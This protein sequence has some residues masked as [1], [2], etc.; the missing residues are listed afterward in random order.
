MRPIFILSKPHRF[1]VA[2]SCSI[3]LMPF[4][5][6]IFHFFVSVFYSY[7]FFFISILHIFLSFWFFPCSI[8]FVVF[9]SYLLFLL[10]YF[11][12]LTIFWSSYLLY[13]LFYAFFHIYVFCFVS[14]YILTLF[15]SIWAFIKQPR[16]S[17]PSLQ[18]SIFV[19]VFLCSCLSL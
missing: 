19:A 9:N 17:C 12:I 5:L 10:F 15:I 16:Y 8:S 13:M 18:L 7:S 14:T 2:L 11:D 6:V 4:C 3:F 1:T